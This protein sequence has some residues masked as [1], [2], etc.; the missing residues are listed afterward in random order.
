M[1]RALMMVARALRL[2]C[3]W[4]GE[5]SLFASWFTMRES[6]P[7][8]RLFLEREE[9]YF[10]GAMGVN[11]VAAELLFVAGFIGSVVLTWPDVPWDMMYGWIAVAV[12]APLTLYP[13]SKT[14][15]L[16]GDLFIR[17]PELHEFVPDDDASDTAG[18][19]APG[20]RGPR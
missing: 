11:L 17:P 8:C 4:C 14:L 16:A 2:R 18:L 9:G 20:E 6:C 12:I 1:L 3:P 15:W 10:T 7:A 19:P 13:F 5:G